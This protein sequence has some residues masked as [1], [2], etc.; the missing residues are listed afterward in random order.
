MGRVAR[1]AP[2]RAARGDGAGRRAVV[3]SRRLSHDCLFVI[4]SLPV[5][6]MFATGVVSAVTINNTRSAIGLAM[7]AVLFS[8]MRRRNGWAAVHD[9][10]TGTRVVERDR[11]PRRTC[12]GGSR[13]AARAA[14]RRQCGHATP[15]RTVCGRPRSGRRRRGASRPRLR[16]GASP[17]GV[18]SCRPA[19][20]AAS[21]R[22][23]ARRVA[24]RPPALADRA[25]IGRRE[26]GCL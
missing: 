14:V 20:C 19:R 5:A 8:T 18:D 6:L 7:M 11:H 2:V 10:L 4:P 22:R 1:Q 9:L 3:R 12:C 24:D 23:A 26:L 25:P 13:A 21:R 15:L 16:S 17:S